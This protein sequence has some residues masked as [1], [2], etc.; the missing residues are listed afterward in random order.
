MKTNWVEERRQVAFDRCR[1][2]ATL[3]GSGPP[4]RLNHES[5][6]QS[7]CLQP[8][9]EGILWTLQL[10]G[11]L[12]IELTMNRDKVND[13]IERLTLLNGETV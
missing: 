10:E 4:T 5:V 11:G 9:R 12:R 13:L 1:A 2:T 8:T 6:Q 7:C 3:R